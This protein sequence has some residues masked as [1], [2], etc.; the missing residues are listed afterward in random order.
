MLINFRVSDDLDLGLDGGL[1]DER[2]RGRLSREDLY[3]VFPLDPLLERDLVCVKFT[4]FLPELN[5]STF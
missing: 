4:V 1:S 2:D 3:G 5:F